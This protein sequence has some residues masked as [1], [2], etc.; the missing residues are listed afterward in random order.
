MCVWRGDGRSVGE[1][2]WVCGEEEG[3]LIGV[4]VGDM[5]GAKNRPVRETGIPEP[6]GL[7]EWLGFPS[8]RAG[9]Q[10]CTGA[11]E[12]RLIPSWILM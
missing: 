2:E 9:L 8:S 5:R 1:G 10:V 4:G 3:C 6:Q 7:S 12:I 11:R